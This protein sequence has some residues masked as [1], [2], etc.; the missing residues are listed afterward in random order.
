MPKL[1]L[2]G[3]VKGSKNTVRAPLPL[4]EIEKMLDARAAQTVTDT[5]TIFGTTPGV[6][7]SDIA[8]GRLTAF[9]LGERLW[10][11]PSVVIRQ[12]LFPRDT[13]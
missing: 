11:I 2:G 10:R 7:R 6:I 9:M 1:R 4:A 3:R 8:A 5:A 13:V 12:K